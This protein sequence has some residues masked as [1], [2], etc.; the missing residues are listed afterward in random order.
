VKRDAERK[1][2]ELAYHA[3]RVEASALGHL[4]GDV[5]DTNGEGIALEVLQ[6][7]QKTKGIVLEESGTG[8]G[9]RC[10]GVSLS[11]LV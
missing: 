2:L 3:P 11:Q 6:Q 1:R 8:D 4:H 9:R 5:D 10:E 7:R